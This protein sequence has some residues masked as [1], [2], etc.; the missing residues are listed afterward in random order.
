M[1]CESIDCYFGVEYKP[2]L[3]F[4]ANVQAVHCLMFR[5]H[6]E[7]RNKWVAEQSNKLVGLS[8]EVQR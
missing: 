2:L 1:L 3:E 7:L 6:L 4:E 5:Q 8:A